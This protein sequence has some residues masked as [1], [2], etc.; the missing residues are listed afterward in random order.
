MNDLFPETIDKG[1]PGSIW[2]VGNWQI[3]NFQGFMQSREEGRGNWCFQIYGFG[4]DGGDW[5]SVHGLDAAGE[6]IMHRVWIDAKDRLHIAGQT[7]GR[8]HWNH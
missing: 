5:C 8:A 7:Y 2:W 4:A 1:R 3:R 6:Q